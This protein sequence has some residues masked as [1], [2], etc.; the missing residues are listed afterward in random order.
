MKKKK[1]P[2]NYYSRDFENIK[3]SLVQHA[4]RYYPDTFQ[5]F[6]EAGFGSLM[7]DTVA[8]VGDMLSFY[9]DYQVNESFLDT[10]TEQRNIIKIAK[11]MGYSYQSTVSSQGL[12]TFY[13]YVPANSVGN[14]IDNRYLPTLKKNST[15]KAENGVQFILAEDVVFQATAEDVRVGRRDEDGNITYYIVRATGTVISGEFQNVV[16][17]V[18]DFEK[19]LKV[20][21]P[22]QNITEII[23]VIDRE[24]NL[25]YEV[26]HLT[27]D[28]VYVPVLKEQEQNPNLNQVIRPFT[29]PRRF[30]VEN[31]GK[32]TYLQFGQG[33]DTSTSSKQALFDP[34]QKILKYYGKN[35]ISNKSFDPVNLLETDKFGIVPHN[36]SLQIVARTNRNTE[37]NIGKGKLNLVGD[38]LLEF[39]EPQSLSPSIVSF[40]RS[41]LEVNNEEAILGKV[42]EDSIE[43]IKI[44]SKTAFASQNRAV[45]AEDYS[46]IIY[47][48]PTQFGSVKRTSVF[49]DSNSFKRN[50]NIY[51]L[52]EDEDGFLTN[53]NEIVKQNLKTW[54]NN[55]KMINDTIDILDA[56]IL[57]IGIE[58]QIIAEIENNRFETLS[59]SKRALENLFA[60][61]PEIGQP[62]IV[63]DIIKT[64]KNV[65][66]VLDVVSV[67]VVNKKGG[68]YSNLAYD[69]EQN[70]SSD[71]RYIN[72]PQNVIFELKYPS[73]DITGVIS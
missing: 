1:I 7:M 62:I 43:E 55:Y 45:T 66:G 13:M 2:I 28:I 52:S 29:V 48:M 6:S 10:A 32:D 51:V 61:K 24:G 72:L 68:N 73:L 65:N 35:Y 47:R 9:L 49:R 46:S 33:E 27:Q 37:V 59:R 67:N 54:L 31:E 11:Q 3:E 34:S 30:V 44:K 70:L 5:D 69:L 42:E 63:S 36:T 14:N 21:V 71:G 58:F 39:L 22:L 20:K 60:I 40:M 19:F 17:E 53:T 23:S 50:L 26:P 12:A 18:G 41:N 57:N 8:Y 25:Y 64:L 38:I 4:K 56:K 16:V 15:F